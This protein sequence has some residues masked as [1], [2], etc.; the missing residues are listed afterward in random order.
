LNKVR[1]SPDHGTGYDI[2]GKGLADSTSFKNAIFSAIE[3]FKSRKLFE[4]LNKNP[5][6]LSNSKTAKK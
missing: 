4:D 6:N 5:L 2:A 3:I 1:T